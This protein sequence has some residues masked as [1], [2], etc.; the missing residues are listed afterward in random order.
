MDIHFLIYIFHSIILGN[1]EEVLHENTE[2]I[3]CFTTAAFIVHSYIILRKKVV[4]CKHN[5]IE[6]LFFH[7]VNVKSEQRRKSKGQSF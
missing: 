7:N 1:K 4:E 2:S 6:Y 5:L 3:K